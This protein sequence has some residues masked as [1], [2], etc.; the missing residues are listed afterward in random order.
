MPQTLSARAPRLIHPPIV[1]ASAALLIGT[2]VTD[3]CYVRTLLFQWNNFSIWLITG[4]LLLA[5]AAGLGLICDLLFH[6]GGPISPARF[7]LVAVAALLSLVNAFV[8]SRDAYTAVMPQGIALS[9]LVALI[10]LVVVW[11]GCNITPV[12]E[13]T[14]GDRS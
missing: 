10:L 7:A 5:A 8:H 4:G 14:K 13:H 11:L 9:A 2:L 6:R 12:R 1:A 3:V